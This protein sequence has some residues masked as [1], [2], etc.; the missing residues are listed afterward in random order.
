MIVNWKSIGLPVSR[1]LRPTANAAMKTL[2]E[3]GSMVLSVSIADM[4]S[5]A[6]RAAQNPLHPPR[7]PLHKPRHLPPL[8]HRNK[9]VPARL[10]LPRLV[11]VGHGCKADGFF[12]KFSSVRG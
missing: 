10:N 9:L 4:K 3:S 1:H 8:A 6:L 12:D 5:H 11:E 2:R 7:H